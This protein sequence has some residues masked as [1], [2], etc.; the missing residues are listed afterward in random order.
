MGLLFYQTGYVLIMNATF[1]KAVYSRIIFFVANFKK[2]SYLP[3][4]GILFKETNTQ[5]LSFC[6]S[7]SSSIL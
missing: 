2:N 6:Q 7:Y 1:V 5:A 4:C 3:K